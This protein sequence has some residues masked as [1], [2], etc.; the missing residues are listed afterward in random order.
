MEKNNIKNCPFCGSKAELMIR[1]GQ[2]DKEYYDVKCTKKGC[3]L[4]EGADWYF[5]TKQEVVDL[6]NKR[7]H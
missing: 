4:E 5:D 2:S 1:T 3:Y 7:K 6:W